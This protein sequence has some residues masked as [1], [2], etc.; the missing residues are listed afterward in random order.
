MYRFLIVIEKTDGN[1][2]AFSPD[3]PRCVSTEATREKG[4]LNMYET[5]ELHVQGLKENVLPILETTPFAEYVTITKGSMKLFTSA[6]RN[7]K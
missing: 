3:M 2:S 4:E 7:I 5:V 6:Y 1:Y